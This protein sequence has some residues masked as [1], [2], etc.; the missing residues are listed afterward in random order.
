MWMRSTSTRPNA[1]STAPRS[2]CNWSCRV[3]S[4]ACSSTSGKEPLFHKYK[5]ETEIARIH[6]REV[7]LECG[8][9]IVIDPTEAL[10]AIDVNS[11]SF[12]ADDS[13]EETAYQLNLQAATR[14]RPATASARPRRR[15]RQ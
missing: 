3:T 15:D 8:G 13:A 10:V 6:K 12:R 7:P 2:S 5:L 9:S 1:L 11:G 4:A 14:N